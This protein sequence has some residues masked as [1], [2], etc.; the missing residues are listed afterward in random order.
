MRIFYIGIVL[1]LGC[2]EP[3]RIE[4][5]DAGTAGRGSTSAPLPP[6]GT[7]TEPEP[8]ASTS[9]STTTGGAPPAG[10][11][12]SEEGS[13][14]GGSTTTGYGPGCPPGDTPLGWVSAIARYD[15]ED[16]ILIYASF[17]LD[18]ESPAFF[19]DECEDWRAEIRLGPEQQV[20]G[21]YEVFDEVVFGKVWKGP[22]PGNGFCA[23][24]SQNPVSW[25]TVEVVDIA[26]DSVEARLCNTYT[27]DVDVN[28]SFTATMCS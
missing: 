23:Y 20:S 14:S 6:A 5:G 13:S 24:I 21:I 25:G 1:S 2:V 15:G 10:S 17:E 4:S 8:L 19:V 9:T 18:C 16:L 22:D 27:L 28:G 26:E 3:P 7:T 11:S 12:S